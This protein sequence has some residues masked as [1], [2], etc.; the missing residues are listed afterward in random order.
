MIWET[1][2]IREAEIRGMRRGM[3]IAQ[4]SAYAEPANLGDC[5]DINWSDAEAALDAAIAAVR[6]GRAL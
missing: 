4:D 2:L 3:E 6:E 1:D 5:P